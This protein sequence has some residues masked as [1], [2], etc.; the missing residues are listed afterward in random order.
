VTV[1]P[2]LLAVLDP[3]ERKAFAVAVATD[4]PLYRQMAAVVRQRAIE[5]HRRQTRIEDTD[6]IGRLPDQRAEL[7][8]LVI[9]RDAKGGVAGVHPRQ[10]S[11][12]GPKRRGAAPRSPKLTH[13]IGRKVP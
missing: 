2:A 4:G 10:M 9:D 11:R 3:F 12:S 5:E 8:Q 13:R 1:E 6:A 7:F